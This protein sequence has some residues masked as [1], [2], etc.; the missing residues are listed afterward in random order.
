VWRVRAAAGR[1]A[2][3]G[4]FDLRFDWSAGRWTVTRID[5]LEEKT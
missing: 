1:S 5:M 4:V 2:P 3:P